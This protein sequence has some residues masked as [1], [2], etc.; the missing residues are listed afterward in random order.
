MSGRKKKM[1]NMVRKGQRSR[2]HN[3]RKRCMGTK[4]GIRGKGK[5]NKKIKIYPI[6][7]TNNSNRCKYFKGI[8][9]NC[10][11]LPYFTITFAIAVFK[12]LEIKLKS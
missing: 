10:I 2:F 11:I 12:F 9:C 1:K 6:Q 7:K 5:G 8:F 4:R 3:T